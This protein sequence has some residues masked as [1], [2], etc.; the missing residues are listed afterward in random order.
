MMGFQQ[1]F[2]VSQRTQSEKEGEIEES[3]PSTTV[4]RELKPNSTPSFPAR[5]NPFAVVGRDS[6]K[7][8]R[9]FWGFSSFRFLPFVSLLE[10]CQNLREEITGVYVPDTGK[11]LEALSA[12]AS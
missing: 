10:E 7:G 2:V 4:G 9:Q 1:L 12:S 11:M 5:R 8:S 6:R 3:R